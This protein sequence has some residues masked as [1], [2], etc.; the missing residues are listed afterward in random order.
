MKVH[1]VVV[2][3][4]GPAGSAAA[5]FLAQAGYDVALLEKARF[6]RDKAC[7]DL[8]SAK[9]LSLLERLGCLDAVAQRA[10]TPI[11]G[12]TVY[13]NGREFSRSKMPQVPGLPPH[14]H[15]IPRVELDEILFRRAQHVGAATVEDCLVRGLDFDRQHVTV[16]ATVSGRPQRFGGRVVVGA[17]GAHS[18]VARAAGLTMD[19]PRYTVPALRAYCT[20]LPV[21][22]AILYLEEEFFPGYAWIFPIKD[23]LSNVGVGMV[24]ESLTRHGLTLNGF[25]AR[26]RT[27]IERLAAERGARV[28]LTPSVGWVIKTYGGARRNYFDRGLLIGDAGCFVDPISGEGT[29]LALETARIASE[30]ID[31]AFRRGDCSADGLATYES[32]WR[33]RYDRDL[34]VA[35]L[36][37]S[38]ARNRH[39]TK[40]WAQSFRLMGMTAAGDPDYARTVGGIMAGLVPARDGL[41]PNV[42]LKSLV[43]GPSFWMRAFDIT[44]ERWLTDLMSGGLRLVSWQ[45]KVLRD[46]LDD[47]EWSKAWLL[48]VQA[49]WL[50]VLRASAPDAR[51]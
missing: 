18:I 7:G 19:D 17:D 36:M 10:L 24:K 35:D 50:E 23:D 20:G 31:D 16:D 37:V 44:P 48:E 28:S 39:L 21:R 33:T 6:P 1:D 41:S 22:E 45:A 42:L 51:R 34:R 3:G 26:F 30:T 12:A 15:A 14:G 5:I 46:S 32:R 38:L 9:G 4:A 8:V 2:V 47:Y 27:F 29:P 40:L 13:L 43:H 49:K 11:D 25:Y